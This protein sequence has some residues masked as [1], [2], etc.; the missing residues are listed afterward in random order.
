MGFRM[1]ECLF[2]WSWF[3]GNYNK[4]NGGFVPLF[5]RLYE[6]KHIHRFFYPI[7]NDGETVKSSTFLTKKNI[8]CVVLLSV[9]I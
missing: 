8:I 7:G 6:N 9:K 4:K 5:D 3:P 1:S 2:W